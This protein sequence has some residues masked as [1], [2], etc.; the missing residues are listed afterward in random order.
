MF[1]LITTRRLLGLL[2]VSALAVAGLGFLAG[3]AP[4]AQ[5]ELTLDRGLLVNTRDRMRVC[6]E[7]TPG[8]TEAPGLAEPAPTVRAKLGRA[9]QVVHQHPDW[10]AAGLGD[11]VPALEAGCRAKIPSDKLDRGNSQ[12]VGRGKTNNP[13]PFRTVI[14]VLDEARAARI[15]GDRPATLVPFE[16][17]CPTEEECVEV[18]SS[19]IVRESALESPDFINPYLTLAVGLEPSRPITPPVGEKPMK[20]GNAGP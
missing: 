2:G 18:T 12:A 3:N 9:M 19:V 15:L 11:R 16:M 7:E 1:P 5:A 14:V 10:Q 20:P 17:M 6:V 13:G 8:L 4:P